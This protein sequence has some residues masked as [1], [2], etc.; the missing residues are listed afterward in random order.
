MTVCVGEQ[1]DD[2]VGGS[3]VTCV[4]GQPGDVW[5]Q[6]GDHGVGVERASGGR[7]LW[8]AGRLCRTRRARCSGPQAGS[9]VSVS[10]RSRRPVAG[11]EAGGSRGAAC[12]LLCG[13]PQQ[14]LPHS[15]PQQSLPRH[16]A[17]TPPPQS[18]SGARP[19]GER[20]HSRWAAQD[21]PAAAGPGV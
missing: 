1:P 19:L 5:G 9:S 15:P 20:R 18:G 12:P 16:P 10:R 21:G 8:E 14:P 7:G 3:L 4:G 13:A 6:P 11:H 2:R 17:L